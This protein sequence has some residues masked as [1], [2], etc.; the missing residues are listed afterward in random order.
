MLSDRIRQLDQLERC[1]DRRSNP[2]FIAENFERNIRLV[3][4]LRE[5]A[6]QRRVSVCQL[7]LPG[8]STAAPMSS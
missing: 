1:D 2:R 6:A 4:A 3:A 7:A 8:C 5:F